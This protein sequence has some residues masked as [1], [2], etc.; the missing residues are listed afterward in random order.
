MF[1]QILIGTAVM[2]VTIL[3]GAL[4]ALLME[5]GF[6]RWHRWL[7]REPHRP[8]L[9]LLVMAVSLWVLGT[10]TVGVWLWAFIFWLLGAFVTMEASVY[11]A[12]VTYTTLGFGDILLPHQWRILAGMTSANGL[13]NFG[14]MTALLVEALRHVRLSQV[15]SRTGR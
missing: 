2:M 15:N 9:T 10:I 7:M 8:K 1:L 14:L 5:M 11:F 3:I 13:L 6:A 12:L 4:S